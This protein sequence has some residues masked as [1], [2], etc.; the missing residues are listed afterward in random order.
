MAVKTKSYEVIFEKQGYCDMMLVELISNL[1]DTIL[2]DK[3]QDE[4]RNCILE[5]LKKYNATAAE[6]GEEFYLNSGASHFGIWLRNLD[7]EADEA[8][9]R[10][11]LIRF[12]NDYSI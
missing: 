1:Q 5:T 3:L 2:P 12:T 4:V 6:F 7:S 10:W 8:G 11:A 9:E